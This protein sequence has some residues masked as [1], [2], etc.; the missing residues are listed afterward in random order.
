M[1][2]KVDDKV[3]TKKH[4]PLMIHEN[5]VMF[6]AQLSERL[7]IIYTIMRRC[8]SVP[9]LSLKIRN[10]V[11]FS[12]NIL[13]FILGTIFSQSNIVTIHVPFSSPFGAYMKRSWK[14][15]NDAPIFL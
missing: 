15:K 5:I 4:S 6:T 9:P 7:H 10:D 1:M 13:H 12:I 2:I 3:K 8:V 14:K 11:L